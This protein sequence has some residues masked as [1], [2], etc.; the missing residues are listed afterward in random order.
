MK[1]SLRS[2][3]FIAAFGFVSSG[4]FAKGYDTTSMQHGLDMLQTEVAQALTEY[5]IDVDPA[6]LSMAQIAVIISVLNDPDKDSGG[7]NA[8]TAIEA[9]IRDKFN[10]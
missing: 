4:A 10:Q 7:S 5:Q 3:A 8:K 6:T 9:A 1:P 2:L